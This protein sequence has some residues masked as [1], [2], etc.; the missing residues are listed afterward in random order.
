MSEHQKLRDPNREAQKQN[1]QIKGCPGPSQSCY[2]VGK[3]GYA[4]WKTFNKL[5]GNIGL[6]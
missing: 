6:N 4:K 3:G 2:R 1:G 5:Q